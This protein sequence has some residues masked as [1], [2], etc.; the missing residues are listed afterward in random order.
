MKYDLEFLY[1]YRTTGYHIRSGA[2]WVQDGGKSSRYFLSLEKARQSSDVINSL[3]DSTGQV[4]HSDD[5]ILH[6]A[7]AYY[8]NLYKD[9]PTSGDDIDSY[10]N[11]IPF[12]NRLDDDT[13]LK[14]GGLVTY[15]KCLKSLNKMKKISPLV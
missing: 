9:R 2:K 6:T 12:E 15:D 4:Q 11:S 1:E 7:K 3:K 10:F 5:G 8:E 14:C 13:K